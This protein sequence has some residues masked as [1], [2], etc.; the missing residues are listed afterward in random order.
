MEFPPVSLVPPS[1]PRGPHKRRV[2]YLALK[3][4]ILGHLCSRALALAGAF[5]GQVGD[6]FVPSLWPWVHLE[7]SLEKCGAECLLPYCLLISA[8][9][10]SLFPSCAVD[11]S[12]LTHWTVAE[13]M[14]WTD[15]K[16]KSLF[17]DR[18]K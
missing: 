2:A 7:K 18:F 17:S 3:S 16:R 8:L 6:R 9:G 15:T 4:G 10:V 11:I 12:D 1:Q 5:G 13:H 14:H